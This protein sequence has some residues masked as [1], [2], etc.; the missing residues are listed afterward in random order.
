MRINAISTIPFQRKI[1]VGK[2][3]KSLDKA[4]LATTIGGSYS[5]AAGVGLGIAGTDLTSTALASDAMG[6]NSLGIVPVSLDITAKSS[7]ALAL[8]VGEHQSTASTGLYSSRTM[9]QGL[10]D[11]FSKKIIPSL[12]KNLDVERDGEP[13]TI[14]THY[15]PDIYSEII[16]AEEVLDEREAD[17]DVKSFV[18]K[19]LP[20]ALA[21]DIPY[22]AD[23]DADEDFENKYVIVDN[24]MNDFLFAEDGLGS[25]IED[26]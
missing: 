11:R 3:D 18:Q 7:P 20:S 17:D 10:N 5:T 13:Y 1:R 16:E 4:L 8:S 21:D 26:M 23:V 24:E 6:T 22:R 19:E 25:E 15:G 12:E 2:D 14:N 9:V